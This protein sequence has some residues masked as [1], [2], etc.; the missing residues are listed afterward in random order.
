MQFAVR[1]EHAK[2][3]LGVF[4]MGLKSASLS[5]CKSFSL[6]GSAQDSISGCRWTVESIA[7][8]WRCDNLDGADA[9]AAFTDAFTKSIAPASGA[10]LIWER[11]ERL[12]V[13]ATANDLNEFLSQTLSELQLSLGITYHRFLASMKLKIRLVTRDERA[14]IAM[15]RFVLPVD[16]FNHPRSGVAGYPRIFRA[17]LADGTRLNLE[18]HV[19]P[20]GARDS[21]FT[22]GRLNGSKKHGFYIYRNDRLIQLG[23]WN[24]VAAD[25][26]PALSLARVK[27]D[28]PAGTAQTNIQKTEVQLSESLS[29]SIRHALSDGISFSEYLA[30]A[31]QYFATS[32]R[33]PRPTSA[34]QLA[35]GKGVPIRLQRIYK[36]AL[37]PKLARDISFSWQELER[38]RLFELN[39]ADGEIILNVKYRPTILE[40]SSAS[41]ADAILF[42]TLLFLLFED[43]LERL[44]S[45]TKNSAWLERCHFTLMAAVESLQK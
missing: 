2:S 33:K 17:E 6:I 12:R 9:A 36:A 16:P 14:D 18:A 26:D 41:G 40:G 27:I 31:R 39:R 34:I 30:T 22:L 11:L 5:Q 15:P 7:D 4:G 19:W 38:D 25:D 23:G 21:S 32:V 1:S 37:S 10:V 44:R 29:I 3:D 8:N 28:L 45:S 42:K 13:P 35:L 24:G 20:Q 43:E